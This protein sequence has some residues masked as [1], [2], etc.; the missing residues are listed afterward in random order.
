[1]DPS[2]IKRIVSEWQAH[3][4]RKGGQVR[5]EAKRKASLE[6]AK[7]ARQVRLDNRRKGLGK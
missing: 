6:S 5:S 3:L 7:K 2:D 1:M 4:G